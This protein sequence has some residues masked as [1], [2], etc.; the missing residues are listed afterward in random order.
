MD[1]SPKD[2]GALW[3]IIARKIMKLN[4]VSEV[5]APNAIPSAAAWI[6]RPVVVAKLWL[7]LELPP[8]SN[9][10]DSREGEELRRNPEPRLSR[11]T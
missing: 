3:T 1:V 11:E 9:S 4:P 2:A 7:R 10:P 8:E 6:T 5:D